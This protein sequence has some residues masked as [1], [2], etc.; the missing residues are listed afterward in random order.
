MSEWLKYVEDVLARYP[1]I[2]S[3]VEAFS[4]FAAVV[5]SLSI[6]LLSQRANRTKIRA[7]G[8]I[9]RLVGGGIDPAQAPRY[10]TVS[11]TN[12]GNTSLRLPFAFFN[13]RIPFHRGYATVNPLDYYGQDR[14][15]PR[16]QYPVSVESRTSETIYISTVDM[17][18]SNFAQMKQELPRFKRFLFRWTIARIVTEDHVIFRV[19]LSK[20][21][22]HQIKAT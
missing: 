2:V 13:W 21:L 8:S 12:V 17:M 20:D 16:R 3:A 14:Y 1:H 5:T 4:T 9:G 7:Y 22:R 10:L 15:I 19:K 6:A 18:I 11:V